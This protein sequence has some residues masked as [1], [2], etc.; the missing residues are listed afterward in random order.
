[1]SILYFEREV[2][3]SFWVTS[4]KMKNRLEDREQKLYSTYITNFNFRSARYVPLT[5]LRSDIN[6]FDPKN[7]CFTLHEPHTQHYDIVVLL[8]E[9]GCR[10]YYFIPRERN[11]V[12]QW[13]ASFA[14]TSLVV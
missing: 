11:R 12:A 7:L 4:T 10:S 2:F 9:V 13:L 8:K 14:I 1:M 3:T 6:L 5:S